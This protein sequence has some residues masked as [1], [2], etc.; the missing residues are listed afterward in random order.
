MN[1]N[2]WTELSPM[3]VARWN[4]GLCAIGDQLYAVGGQN[5]YSMEMYNDDSWKSGV[6]LPQGTTAH[7][8]LRG[9]VA[10]VDH[11]FPQDN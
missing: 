3:S 1:G 6:S 4:F 2:V 10:V 11:A 7:G 8:G 5:N 9:G